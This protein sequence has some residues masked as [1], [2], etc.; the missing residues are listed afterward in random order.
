MPP[1]GRGGCSFCTTVVSSEILDALEQDLPVTMLDS[2]TQLLCEVD[3]TN[4]RSSRRLVLCGVQGQAQES[5]EVPTAHDS[6]ETPQD[7]GSGVENHSRHTQMEDVADTDSVASVATV[8]AEAIP[9]DPAEEDD[10]ESLW[11][12]G[13]DLESAD[14]AEEEIPFRHPGVR[15]CQLGFRSLDVVQ[16]SDAFQ[17]RGCLMQNVPRFLRGPFRRALRVALEEILKGART[18]DTVTE[19]RGWKLF[20]MLPRMLLHRPGRGEMVS[21]PKL[22]ARFEMFVRG[23]WQALIEAGAGLCIQGS[24]PP[25]PAG[26]ALSE[27]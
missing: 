16:L 20:L 19:E 27:D 7:G 1:S 18:N 17:Q 23:E 25:S 3:N 12:V 26:D 4:Q 13:G 5:D 11:S 6:V 9:H 24:K 15:S 14:D 22:V 21:K 2:D 8:V 10:R